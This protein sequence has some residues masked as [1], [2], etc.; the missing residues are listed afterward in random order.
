MKDVMIL[1][2][3]GQIGM[4]IARRMGYGMKIV[5][6]DKRKENA[7]AIAEIMN[8]AGFDAEAMEMDL[9][10]RESI[11]NLIAKAREYGEISMLV[12]AAGVSPSQAP[13]EAILKV[14]LLWRSIL[15]NTVEQPI[16]QKRSRMMTRV[17]SFRP[18]WK[19]WMCMI[20][21]S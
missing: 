18:M 19:I 7:Q 13:I 1:T 12:N 10:S 16:R 3:A 6:G 17:R 15:Q 21:S 9:S 11:L 4:A 2:G 20:R 14:D 5:V 8:N